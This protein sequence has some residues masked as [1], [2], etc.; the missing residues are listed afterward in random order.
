MDS[1]LVTL[2]PTTPKLMDNDEDDD[3]KKVTIDGKNYWI[4]YHKKNIDLPPFV[5]ERPEDDTFGKQIGSLDVKTNTVNILDE[6]EIDK[7]G[8]LH[9]K[10]YFPPEPVKPK[11]KKEKVKKEVKKIEKKLKKEAP[12]PVKKKEPE[13]IPIA[14]DDDIF[15][16]A[17]YDGENYFIDRE[18]FNVYTVGKNNS[19]GDYVGVYHPESDEIVYNR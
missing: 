9:D 5:Y 15:V 16:K 17:K 13:P 3:V 2:T 12:K 4:L 11:P 10:L 7:L 14:E 6:D 8:E 19:L 18:S 1:R